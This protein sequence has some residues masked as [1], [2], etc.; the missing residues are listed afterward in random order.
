MAINYKQVENIINQQY[1]NT[2]QKDGSLSL[3]SLY[4]DF[5]KQ[6]NISNMLSDN[7]LTNGILKMLGV[8]SDEEKQQDKMDISKLTSKYPIVYDKVK[9]KYYG[10]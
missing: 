10:K 4:Y 1:V 6:L 7:I 3:N 8:K 2:K 5:F 9:Y